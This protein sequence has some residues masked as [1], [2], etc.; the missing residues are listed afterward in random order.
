LFRRSLWETHPFNEDLHPFEDW[1]F[2]VGCAAQGARFACTG[3][4]DFD[5]NTHGDEDS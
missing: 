2:W 3:R 4:V 1:G 5:Y